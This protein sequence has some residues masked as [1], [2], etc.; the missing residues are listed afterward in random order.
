MTDLLV[1]LL[2]STPKEIIYKVVYLTQGKVYPNLVDLEIGVAEK[3]AIQALTRASGRKQSEIEKD[4]K[5]TGD[6][7]G[8]AKNL[9]AGK[10]QVIFFEHS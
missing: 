8:A 4:L 10:R 7:G 9:I 3:L 2:K 1:N 5:K 6:I